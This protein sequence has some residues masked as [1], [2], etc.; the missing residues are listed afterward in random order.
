[1]QTVVADMFK[2][3]VNLFTRCHSMYHSRIFVQLIQE[4][5]ARDT[6]NWTLSPVFK[7]EMGPM[8]STFWS[9]EA[10]SFIFWI[11][12][13]QIYNFRTQINVEASGATDVIKHLKLRKI[14]NSLWEGKPEA[15][16]KLL[17][18]TIFI[19]SQ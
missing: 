16:K 4:N 12:S 9:Y 5:Y 1:M 10:I 3:Y 11:L 14:T 2:I 13:F 15:A 6:L 18:F 19:S 17:F 8:Q 7:C